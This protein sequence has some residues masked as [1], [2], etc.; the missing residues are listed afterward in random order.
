MPGYTLKNLLE[1]ENAAEKF[2][3]APGLEAHF[4]SSELGL[5]KF[6]LSLQKL[7]PGFR[8]PFGHRHAQ[9][10]E[11]YL[12]AEGSARIKLD[13]EIVELRRWDAVRIANETIRNLEAGPEGATILAIGAPGP[14]SG[15]PGARE[16]RLGEAANARR[17]LRGNVRDGAR[18][19]ENVNVGLVVNRK[20]DRP[21]HGHR[22]SILE[23]LDHF[24]G[25]FLNGQ[26]VAAVEMDGGWHLDLLVRGCAPR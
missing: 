16:V 19:D 22:E 25:G 20:P 12:V 9:Q 21:H 7:A 4:A 18:D 3:L 2:G 5:G 13:G 6:G 8:I 23:L 15:L 24:L 14:D 26:R 11:I 17:R 10:E 1:V